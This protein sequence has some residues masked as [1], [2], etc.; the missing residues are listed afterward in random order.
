VSNESSPTAN[1][2]TREWALGRRDFLIFGTAAAAGVAATS[3]AAGTISTVVAPAAG[4]ILSVGFVERLQA[5]APVTGAARFR[6][7]D[8]EFLRSGARVTVLGAFRPAALAGAPVSIRLSAFYPHVGEQGRL[9]FMAWSQSLD[10]RGVLNASRRTS[11]TAPLDENGTL[12][13]SVERVDLTPSRFGRFFAAAAPSVGSPARPDL[14]TL[15]SSGNVCRLTSG[16][17]GDVRLREGTYF[18]AL[19]RSNSDRAPNWRSI[20]IQGDEISAPGGVLRNGDRPVP[21]EYIALSLK[22]ATA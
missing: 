16:N 12:P 11:F 18:I 4:S 14:A 8:A 6:Q 7:A 2:A 13:I 17:S 3:L 10:A 9:P 22:Y 15:E 20:S 5:D 21:F 1:T 19:R